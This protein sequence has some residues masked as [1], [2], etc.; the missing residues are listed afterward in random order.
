MTNPPFQYLVHHLREYIKALL[1]LL[2]GLIPLL[3]CKPNAVPTNQYSSHEA[4]GVIRELP[5]DGQSIVIRHE[6]IPGFMPKMTMTLRV[7]DLR[8]LQGLKEGD[9]VSFQLHVNADEHWIDAVKRIGHT[10]PP[11]S[12]STL[13]WQPGTELHNGDVLPDFEILNEDGKAVRLSE[14][15]GKAVAITFIFTRCPLPEFCPRMTRNFA[16]AN[17]LLSSRSQTLSNWQFLSLSFDPKYDSPTVLKRY[18][19]AHRGPEKDGWLFGVLSS[20]T[21]SKLA[22][23]IDLH[24][25]HEGESFSHNLRTVVLDSQGRIHRQLDG[26]SWSAEQLVE[27]LIGAARTP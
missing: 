7:R 21:I 3:G 18:A 15:R 8:M 25:L 9:E 17:R 19:N 4:R 2:L 20:E 24:V 10:N 26:N 16:K 1:L 23:L 6:E 14:F 5:L 12:T 27:A 22:P 13:S 11:P